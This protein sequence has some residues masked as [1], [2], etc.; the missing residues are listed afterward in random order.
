M[1]FQRRNRTFREWWRA[2]ITSRERSSGVLIG[3]LG[4]FWIGALGRIALGTTPVSLGEVAVLGLAV[5]TCC[6]VAGFTFPKLV[7]IILFPFS[8]F[9]GSN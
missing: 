8:T 3:G 2:P 6:A 1:L 7:T 4:G 5:A 9:G